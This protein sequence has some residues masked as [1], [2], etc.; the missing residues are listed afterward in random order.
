MLFHAFTYLHQLRI[1]QV[2]RCSPDECR[3]QRS[4]RRADSANPCRLTMA[5]GA[6]RRPR[7]PSVAGL[8]RSDKVDQITAAQRRRKTRK[9]NACALQL[10]VG[11]PR[12]PRKAALADHA[13]LFTVNPKQLPEAVDRQRPIR[14]LLPTAPR[15][16]LCTLH[17][18]LH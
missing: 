6:C 14:K 17:S 1:Q 4:T 10:Y 2:F 18:P 15:I 3:W 5:W 16:H 7:R 12:T 8:H 11:V 13:T 9:E